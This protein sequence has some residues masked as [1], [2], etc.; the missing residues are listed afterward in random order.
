M[1]LNISNSLTYTQPE[2]VLDGKINYVSYKPQGANSYSASETITVKLSSNTDFICLDRSYCKFTLSTSATGTLSVNGGTAVINSIVDNFGGAVLPIARNVH[3]KQ[4]VK[5]QSGTSERKAIDTYAQSC[6]FGSGTGLAVTAATSLTICMPFMSSFETDK[7]IP[8]AVLNGWEQTVTLNPA[9]AVV[10]AGTYTVSNFEVVA[11]MLTPSQL[12]LE[13]IAQGLNNGSTL[14]IPIQLSNSITSPVSSALSQNILVNCGYYSSMNSVTFV[15]KESALA[16]SSKV[17][18][19]YLMCDSN[20]YPKNKTIAG[21][22][23]SVYQTLAGYATDITS[24]SVPDSTQTFNQYSFKTNGE[25]SSGIATANGLVELV[26]DFSSTP[27][28][29]IET[30]INYDGYLEIGRN[31]VLLMTDV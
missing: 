11:A 1:S 14:K 26:L 10:S 28:G 12:Y 9:S 7:V 22:V 24:I 19:W 8:L 23:E 2:S 18:S 4:G 29:T 6:T 3:I 31:A 5:L 16:N 21:A 25:F 30:I 27:T 13:Q 17:S 20:R 15:H